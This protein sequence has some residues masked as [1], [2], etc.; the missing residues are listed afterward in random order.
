[1]QTA[2]VSSMECEDSTDTDVVSDLPSAHSAVI[3]SHHSYAVTSPR[4][5]LA[6]RMPCFDERVDDMDAFLHRF[7]VYADSQGWKKGQWAVYLSALLR[8]KA[9]DVYSRL[10][11]KEAQDYE[12]LKDALLKRF[13]LTE[14]GFKQR[15]KS[16]R[17]ETGEAPTQF[18]A[19]LENYLMRWI[20]LANVPK[21]FDGLINLI[22]R[23]QY[24]ESCPVHLAIFLR[25]RKP[26]DLSELAILAE[27]YLDAHAN[28]NKD[29]TKKPGF[30]D[31]E[32]GDKKNEKSGRRDDRDVRPETERKCFNCGK[33]GHVARSCEMPR[34]CFN[35]GKPGHTDRNCFQ[36][37]KVGAM[38]IGQRNDRKEFRRGCQQSGQSG[39]YRNE[40]GGSDA[41][42]TS[43][44]TVHESVMQCT[45]HDRE[46][47]GECMKSVQKCHAM[48]NAEVTLECG[49][50]LPVIAD[51]CQSYNP[52]GPTGKIIASHN[53]GIIET[54]WR[55][56]CHMESEAVDLSYLFNYLY[57]KLSIEGRG[58]LV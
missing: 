40:R 46:A 32:A 4:K 34:K 9:L 26:K 30:R 14:E 10:P 53:I 25:E 52:L 29:W 56:F 47:C 24:L 15:F 23:E 36:P 48:L 13:N 49:C 31:Q 6:Q 38:N 51:A 44:K 5:L 28:R 21:D 45:A 22:V 39:N 3:A 17:A 8:G 57:R 42:E 37:K 35:C 20:D 2:D 54:H 1:M 19:R 33:I 58:R 27:Q 16:A 50:K 18:I 7:E 41:N 11:V 12:T 55:R 43:L